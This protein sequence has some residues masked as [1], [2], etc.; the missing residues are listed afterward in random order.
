MP[1]SLDQL[2]RA[3][4]SLEKAM[5]TGNRWYKNCRSVRR[6]G[7]KICQDC[8]WRVTIEER[9]RVLGTLVKERGRDT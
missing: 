6:R 1:A 8:P 3:Y 5:A 7:G 4:W 9:E 2:Q